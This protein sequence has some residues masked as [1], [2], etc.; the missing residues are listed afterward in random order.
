MRRAERLTDDVLAAADSVGDGVHLLPEC[1]GEVDKDV[2]AV[3][4]R[5]RVR[6]GHVGRARHA[7][8]ESRVVHRVPAEAQADRQR[9]GVVAERAKVVEN[10]LRDRV[11]VVAELSSSHDSVSGGDDAARP[12]VLTKTLRNESS[13]DIPKKLDGTTWPL[14]GAGNVS[15]TGLAARADAA[16]EEAAT[17]DARRAIAVIR[18]AWGRESKECRGRW[19]AGRQEAGNQPRLCGERRL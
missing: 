3:V 18:T 4:L 15:G 9:A 13:I 7:L 16:I 8:D 5:V 11:G 2:V 19:D 10:G 17:K 6:Q 1:G 12:R 14:G